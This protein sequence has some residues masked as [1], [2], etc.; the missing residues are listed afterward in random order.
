V[1]DHLKSSSYAQFGRTSSK[2]IVIYRGN[3][4]NWGAGDTHFWNVAVA[5]PLKQAASPYVFLSNSVVLRQKGVH[6]NRR[7]P[8]TWGALGPRLLTV[9]VADP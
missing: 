8:E 6:R 9:D 7:E 2:I 4:R 1:A 3:L 5:G